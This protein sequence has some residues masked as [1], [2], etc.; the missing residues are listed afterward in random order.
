[1]LTSLVLAACLT[2]APQPAVAGVIAAQLGDPAARVQLD[3]FGQLR[4]ATGQL[5]YLD[6]RREALQ[7]FLLER[8]PALGLRGDEQLRAISDLR[9]PGFG[10]RHVRVERTIHGVPVAFDQVR[11]HSGPTGL[12]Y[13]ME[14]ELSPLSQFEYRAP[15]ITPWRAIQLAEGGFQG[16]LLEPTRTELVIL[17]ES[18]EGV[19]GTHL[20]YK[21]RVAFPPRPGKVP[22]IEDDYIDAHTGAVLARIPKVYTEGTSTPMTLPTL[23]GSTATVNVDQFSDGVLLKDISRPNGPIVYTIDLK[24]NGSIY[25][26][27]NVNS[28]FPDSQSMSG[29]P[30]SVAANVKLSVDFYASEFGWDHWDFSTATAGPGGLL[31][32]MA[33]EGDNLANAYFT[34]LTSNGSVF[35]TMHY[36]DGD[37]SNILN[38]AK[39]LDVSGHELGHGVVEGTAGLVYHNQSGA[40][41]EHF[42]DVFGWMLKN[43]NGQANDYIGDQCVGSNL[44]PALRDMCNPGSVPDAQPGD[45]AHYQQ[46]PDDDA[47]DHGGVHGNSGIPNHAACLF[48]NAEQGFGKLGAIWFRALRDHMGPTASFNEMVSATT[49]ACKELM[50]A[51]TAVQSDCDN[52]VNAWAAV[53]LA[54]PVPTSGSCP[55][56]ST[57]NGS[58]CL[59]NAGYQP[60]AS[61]NCVAVAAQSCPAHAHVDSASGSCYCDTGYAVS[62]DGKSCEPLNQGGCAAHSHQEGGSCVCDPCYAYQGPQPGQ[63]TSS[64]VQVPSCTVCTDPAASDSSGCP[65]VP[66]LSRDANGKCTVGT[67]GNCGNENFA[68]RCVGQVLIYCDDKTNGV[69]GEKVVVSDCSSVAGYSCGP[70]TANGGFNCLVT[71]SHCGS[72]P[73]TGTCNGNTASYCSSGTVQTTD[74]GGPCITFP[75]VYQGTTYTYDYC[76]PCSGGQLPAADG[77]PNADGSVRCV[78]ASATTTSGSTGGSS[79]GTGT[80]SSSAGSGGGAK[81]GCGATGDGASMGLIL[82][83]VGLA[84]SRRKR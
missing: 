64:C 12:V 39:C 3:R 40:L 56:N 69:A 11:V 48:R 84:L 55:A 68:G 82:G 37:G 75:Y 26:V 70:D 36:G 7:T 15:T 27:P 42:A 78:A 58:G 9:E 53:G 74:C 57:A 21:T 33:H 80:T 6:D 71:S 61:G 20:A 32:G 49:T 66:G 13:A 2:A 51:G 60:D 17:G 52:L 45:M 29:E 76:N 63:E 5:G 30:G 73:V 23:D 1:M 44:A 59:C 67:A 77:V 25:S 41:N 50:T 38:T 79:G 65:C 47:H 28:A 54:T 16:K 24:N 83:L 8:A 46:L 19:K 34:T 43:H 22:V 72:T 4:L 62:A 81:S 14:S 10:L 18:L 35:G 31:A